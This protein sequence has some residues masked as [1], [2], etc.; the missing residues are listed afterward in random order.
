MLHARA[1]PAGGPTTPSALLAALEETVG[2]AV[3]PRGPVHQ[4]GDPAD[5]RYRAEKA[6][7]RDRGDDEHADRLVG[8]AVDQLIEPGH[9]RAAR[10]RDHPRDVIPPA[11]LGLDQRLAHALVTTWPRAEPPSDR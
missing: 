5:Q 10:G 11:A 3:D 6:R 4:A 8:V 9:H 1:R 7:R 2:D